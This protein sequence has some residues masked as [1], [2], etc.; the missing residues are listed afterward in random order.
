MKKI[1]LASIQ[2]IVEDLKTHLISN[3]ISNITL[4]NN[5]DILFTFSFYRKEKLLISLNQNNPYLS[6]LEVNDK[7]TTVMGHTTEVLRKLIKD[8]KIDEVEIV[9]NDRIVNLSLSKLNDFYELE[10]YSLIIELIP[11]KV[12]LII[13]DKDNKVI[14]ATKYT[15]LDA[16]RVIAKGVNYPEANKKEEYQLGESLS[17]EEIK[18]EGKAII[19]MAS[20]KKEKEKYAK[21]VTFIKSKIKSNKKKLDV[22]ASEIDKANEDLVNQEYGNMI[23]AYAYEPELLREYIK[24]NNLEYV[25]GL[26]PGQN[27]NKYFKK[28]KKSKRTIEM[29]EIELSKAKTEIDKL[30]NYL[31]NFEYYNDDDLLELAMELMPHAFK[32]KPKDKGHKL[33]FVEVEGVKIYFGKNAKQNNEITFSIAKKD[34]YYFHIKD[35]HGAHVL[36]KSN[37][38]TNEMKLLASEICLILSNKSVGDIMYT[39]VKNIKKGTEFAQALLDKYEIITLTKVRES[40]I[41]L[42]K[43]IKNSSF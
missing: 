27:A 38:P 13:L 26:T 3:H 17:I 43:E 2:V 12:N 14:F 5:E 21:L 31:N 33:S 10:E 15:T 9:N 35:Y 7:F 40:T 25:E 37:N 32:T 16:N 23:L 42:L 18:Q 41:S 30:E 6:L 1:S 34:D 28:Y 4:I 11:H 39:Q 19:L 22:L 20:T 8:S 29:D 24:E 36:I